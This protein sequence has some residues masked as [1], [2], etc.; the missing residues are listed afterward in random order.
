VVSEGLEY[1]K[2]A[3]EAGLKP[4]NQAE[5]TAQGEAITR[6]LKFSGEGGTPR[7]S[8]YDIREFVY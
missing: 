4:L 8:R 5:R 7:I 1:A 3:Y 6:G 2:D